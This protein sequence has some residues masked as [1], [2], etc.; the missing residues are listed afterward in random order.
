M[1][2]IMGKYRIHETASVDKEAIIGNGTTIWQ[3]CVIQGD[4]EIGKRCNVGAN[5]FIEN[6]VRVGNGVKIK[7][8]VALYTGVEIEDDVFLGPSCVFTNVSKPRADYPK[9][10]SEYGKTV[11]RHGAT[12][13][14]NATVIC[15]HVVGEYAFI[16]AGAVVTKD[17]PPYALMMGVPAQQKGYVCEC[18]QVLGSS[19]FCTDCG[20]RYEVRGKNLKIVEAV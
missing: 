5:V 4:V 18:G 10:C 1:E 2:R 9:K 15:G 16:A 17:V 3:N 6:G 20:K 11:I 14:A 8:N 19:M 7:N 12:I 13:G